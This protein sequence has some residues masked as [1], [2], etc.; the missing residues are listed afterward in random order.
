MEQECS[1]NRG[2]SG[3]GR[4]YGISGLGTGHQE[5]GEEAG[6]VGLLSPVEELLTL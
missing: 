2:R 1:G 5:L 6:L 3:E 4:E